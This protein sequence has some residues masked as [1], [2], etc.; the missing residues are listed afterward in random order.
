MSSLP[1]YGKNNSLLGS[2]E[3]QEILVTARDALT[4]LVLDHPSY[5]ALPL[6]SDAP[7]EYALLTQLKL[8]R[9]HSASPQKTA[10]S[11][12]GSTL[13]FD[14][15]AS[16]MYSGF[17]KALH[18]DA[19][20]AQVVRP[21]SKPNYLADGQALLAGLKGLDLTW[22]KRRSLTWRS[23]ISQIM[24]Y[25]NPQRRSPIQ[26]RCPKPDCGADFVTYQDKAGALIKTSA[27]TV[28][29]ADDRVDC[30]LCQS[31]LTVWP[32]SQL[33]EVAELIQHI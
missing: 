17:T 24:A 13:P 8:A 33:W 29:W 9:R 20:Q 27:L 30:L 21:D 12:G 23:W 2:L 18:A 28:L 4:L 26:G 25:L 16:D 32:R 19:V 10:S 5:E 1:D 3:R 31:C 22:L 11:A 15:A 14:I 6:G 7:L